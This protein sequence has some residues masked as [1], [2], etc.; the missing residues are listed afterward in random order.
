[1]VIGAIV[2]VLAGLAVV[3]V[4][5]FLAEPGRPRRAAAKKAAKR[6]LVVGDFLYGVTDGSGLPLGNG[7]LLKID[8]NFAV[9]TVLSNAGLDG[10]E[11]VALAP[12]GDLLVVGSGPLGHNTLARI[13]PR[14]G[15]SETV[16][17]FDDYPFVEGLT[18]VGGTLYGSASG[19]E[20]SYC[21]D[22]S[23]HLIRIDPR[24]GKTTEVGTFGPEFVNVEALAYSPKYGLI[25]ADIGTLVPP[26]FKSFHTTPALIRIDP[27]TGEAT[28]IASLPTDRFVCGLSFAPDGTLFGAT[29]PSHFGGRPNQLV[30][31]DPTTGAITPIGDIGAKN[32]VQNVDGIQYVGADKSAEPDRPADVPSAPLNPTHR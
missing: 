26:D 15:Q 14:T 8:P 7:V 19:R 21:P 13:D 3:V 16:A 2:L 1:M 17:T 29:F 18:F 22:C 11:D 24:T 9:S 10:V 27:K 28:R 25:G 4:P 23:N 5:Q 32:G 30:T 12:D 31:I 6:R 20:G